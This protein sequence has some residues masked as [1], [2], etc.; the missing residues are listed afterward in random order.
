ME[1]SSK[2][3]GDHRLGP[4]A[5]AGCLLQALGACERQ[6]LP[7]TGALRRLLEEERASLVVLQGPL[8]GIFKEFLEAIIWALVEAL[9]I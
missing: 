8:A 7:Q 4:A 6:H 3:L 9:L 5:D 1:A 2:A